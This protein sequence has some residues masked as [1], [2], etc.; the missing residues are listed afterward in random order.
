VILNSSYFP[1]F[2]NNRSQI[3]ARNIKN[4]FK[5]L[6]DK[7]RLRIIK[8]LQKKP[9]CVCEIT[10]ILKLAASKVRFDN[11]YVY[12]KEVSNKIKEH[13]VRISSKA[14]RPLIYM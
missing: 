10:E 1:I 13:V 5:A 9:L 3:V 8:M 7:S 11:L 4:I 12:M 14:N 2:S 6:S